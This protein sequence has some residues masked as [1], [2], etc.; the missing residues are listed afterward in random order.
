MSNRF[1]SIFGFYFVGSLIAVI[2]LCIPQ[3]WG[4][5]EMGTQPASA[6]LWIGGI[7]L[8]I[9]AAII[10]VWWVRIVCRGFDTLVGEV[11]VATTPVPDPQ[12]IA[13]A[14]ENEWGRPPSVNEVC[15]VH[16]MLQSGRNQAL[17]NSV[18]GLGAAY[19]ILR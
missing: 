8:L 1:K 11:K 19:L 18:I 12:A 6:A 16:Q 17:V 15:A 7:A 2:V 14:L 10:M 4:H 9:L 3:A 13:V 5:D